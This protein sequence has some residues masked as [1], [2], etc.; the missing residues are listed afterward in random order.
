MN[1]PSR[2]VVAYDVENDR[3]RERVATLLEG[4]GFRVQLS[5]FECLLDGD[6][7]ERL[8]RAL[9]RELERSDEGG[10]V[11]LYRLCT[12]CFRES[13]GLGEVEA[14]AGSEPWIVV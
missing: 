7:L 12:G 2:Y 1:E 10:D 11:R 8:T 6:S 3:T 4:C 13:F 9:T 5:V 14:G